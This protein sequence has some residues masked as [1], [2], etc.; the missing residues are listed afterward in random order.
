MRHRAIKGAHSRLPVLRRARDGTANCE[1]QAGKHQFFYTRAT[2]IP[3][4]SS[5]SQSAKLAMALVTDGTSTAV[6]QLHPS[7]PVIGKGLHERSSMTSV[8]GTSAAGQVPRPHLEGQLDHWTE[9]SNTMPLIRGD[10]DTG[11]DETIRAIRRFCR[12]KQCL[13][14]DVVGA[15]ELPSLSPG[16]KVPIAERK[17]VLPRPCRARRHFEADC[18]VQALISDISPLLLVERRR[19]INGLTLLKYAETRQQ[20]ADCEGS[21]G[22]YGQHLL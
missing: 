18:V 22:A 4:A 19:S 20:P 2:D 1:W 7:I 15:C 5:F 14:R 11:F 9:E 6:S 8:A 10:R 3:A 13:M 17:K 12:A 16:C 21:D